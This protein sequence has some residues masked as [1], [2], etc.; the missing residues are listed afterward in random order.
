MTNIVLPEAFQDLQRFCNWCLPTERARSRKR[1][2]STMDEIRDFYRVMLD[3]I[4][5][6]LDYLNQFSIEERELPGPERNLLLLTLSLAEVANAVELF[7]TQP[8]VIDGFDPERFLA[9]HEGE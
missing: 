2:A 1:L 4:E 7:K 5:A 6:A 3:R 8:G 9:L